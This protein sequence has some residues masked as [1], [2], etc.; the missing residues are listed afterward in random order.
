MTPARMDR[1]EAG[2]RTV[3]AFNEAFNQHDVPAM[4]ALVS[5]DCIFET[6]SP[7]PDGT[8]LTGKRAITDYYAEFFARSPDAHSKAE[9]AFGFGYRCILLWHHTWIDAAGIQQHVRG[10]DIFRVQDGLI[11]EKLS[12]VKG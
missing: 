9:Q 12:Y 1:L 7:A 8:P 11:R 10:A 6:A 5:D 4:L 3:I 2:V